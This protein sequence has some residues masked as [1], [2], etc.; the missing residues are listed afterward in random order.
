MSENK[1][2]GFCPRCG[3][4]MQNGVC[5]SCGYTDH[6]ASAHSQTQENSGTAGAYGQSGQSQWQPYP[7]MQPGRKKN[8]K[9]GW[10]IALAV[11]GALILLFLLIL[12]AVF[13]FSSVGRAVNSGNSRD[14]SYYDDYYDG[15]YYGDFGYDSGYYVPSEDDPY[16]REIVDSTRT[17]LDYGI[18]WIV[19]SVTPD[20]EEDYC[21]YYS[22]YPILEGD[23][24]YSA[25]NDEI[26]RAALEYRDTY[27]EYTGGTS[28]LG[29]VT[30]MDEETISI[31][32]QHSLYEDRGT[33]PRVSALTFDLATGE[34]IE[35][36]EMTEIDEELAMRFRAQ[37][38]TQNGT[39]DYLDS[40]SD[41][42]LLSILRDPDQ[43]FYFYS[44]VG[45]E[46]GFNYESEGYSSGWVSVTLKDQAL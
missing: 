31:V 8:G 9:K 42:E 1:D 26:T 10:V 2:F 40:L 7:G 30:Y 36:R 19:E 20:N 27:R 14:D 3:A 32:F 43:S 29:Y 17:D 37:N 22:T 25:V 44:P 12:V 33:L 39:V 11:I 16:Y 23:A 28:T 21:T 34:L 38:Q 45:L 46:A 18:S 6:R 5:R 4:L 13:F 41:E 15:D 35:P 24:D